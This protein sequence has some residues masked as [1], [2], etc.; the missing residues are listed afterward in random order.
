VNGLVALVRNPISGA[1]GL[2]DLLVVLGPQTQI[3]VVGYQFGEGICG[4]HNPVRMLVEH[5]KKMPSR[6]KSLLISIT[7]SWLLTMSF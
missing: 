2:V 1:L 7:N 5:L 4:P 3:V 6:G